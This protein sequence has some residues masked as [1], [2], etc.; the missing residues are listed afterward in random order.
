VAAPYSEESPQGVG[1]VRAGDIGTFLGFDGPG[2]NEAI[3]SFPT[4]GT[5][6]YDAEGVEVVE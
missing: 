3:V 5:F 4:V 2:S 6:V 1:V